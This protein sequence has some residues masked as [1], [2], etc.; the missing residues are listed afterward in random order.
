MRSVKELIA[1]AANERAAPFT[2]AQAQAVRDV[3]D[4]NDRQPAR[5]KRVSAEAMTAYLRTKLGY[6]R[7]DQTFRRHVRETFGRGWE[8]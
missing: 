4:A 2:P 7:T 1:A 6:T 3:L 5:L 8:K